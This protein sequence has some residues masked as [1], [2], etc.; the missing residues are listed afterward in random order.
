MYKYSE[1]CTK[2]IDRKF[3]KTNTP[4]KYITGGTEALF[5]KV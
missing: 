3:Y 1:G 2:L 4:F 5:Q